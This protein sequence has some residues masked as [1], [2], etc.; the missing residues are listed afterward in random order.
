MEAERVE[1]SLRGWPQAPYK[2]K[3]ETD[4][5]YLR[6]LHEGMRPENLAA[7]RLGIASHNLFTLAYGLVLAHACRRAR[8]RAVRNARRH[9]QPSAAGT[10]RAD[11]QHAA[12]RPGLP[13]G[14]FHERHRL[15]RPP[16]RRK[17]RSRIIFFATHSTSKSIARSGTRL[18]QQFIEAFES[19]DTVSTAP[20]RTQDRT[21]PTA[22]GFAGGDAVASDGTPGRAGGSSLLP[23]RTRHRLVLARERRVGQ[24][25]RCRVEGPVRCAGGRCAARDRRRRS[26]RQP[27][28]SRF[29]RSFS[30]RHNRRAISAGDRKPMSIEQ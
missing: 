16:A 1:A 20:R 3:L 14:R 24:L 7:V 4:A 8:S 2:T 6:M 17:H 21:K 22:P 23:Q 18:E 10:L 12:L 25:D 15:P 30:S 13:A 27:P 29:D 11:R 5:N 26:V 9:G 28:S 19:R